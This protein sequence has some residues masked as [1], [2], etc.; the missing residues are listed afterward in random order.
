MDFVGIGAQE[1]LMIL[2]VAI[3]VVGPNRIVEIGRTIGKVTRA[4]KKTTTDFTSAVS[5]E[6]EL[7]EK[8]K[9]NPQPPEKKG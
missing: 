2:L 9:Q 6:M 5:K 4:I 3:L 7:E 1:I 8:D